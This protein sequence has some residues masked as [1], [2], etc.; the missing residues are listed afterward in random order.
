MFQTIISNSEEMYALYIPS[1]RDSLWQVN[2]VV[3]KACKAENPTKM[4]W[5]VKSCFT[6]KC[7]SIKFWGDRMDIHC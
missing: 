5:C 1:L 7:Q 2:S 6:G 3:T 4:H